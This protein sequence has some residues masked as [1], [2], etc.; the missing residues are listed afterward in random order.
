MN[1]ARI[2]PKPVRERG[3]NAGLVRGVMAI[4]IER[5]FRFREAEPLR[6]GQDIGEIRALQLHPRQDVIAGAVD[7]AVEA[8]DAISDQ[9][10]R[11]TL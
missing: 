11:A 3:Q 10:L 7:D 5:R 4:D 8:R 6:I 9:A 1:I 2:H